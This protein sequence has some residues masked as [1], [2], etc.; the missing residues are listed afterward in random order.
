MRT[1]GYKHLHPHACRARAPS[2]A[3]GPLGAW[4]RCGPLRSAA[5]QAP[6][7]GHSI[8]E[9]RGGGGEGSKRHAG[10]RRSVVAAP[11][12]VS[13][14]RAGSFASSSPQPHVH[15][16][17]LC[18]APETWEPA[19][20]QASLGLPA[21]LAR[22]LSVALQGNP[23][24]L[25]R[26]LRMSDFVRR[27]EILEQE[28]GLTRE[29]VRTSPVRLQ[30]DLAWHAG[31]APGQKHSRLTTAPCFAGVA[32]AITPARAPHVPSLRVAVP[33]GA[34]R[35]GPQRAAG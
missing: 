22:R 6:S 12:A 35:G 1:Q 19:S 23:D 5:S 29:Q 27:C 32:H 14:A 16:C 30:S 33:G 13:A 3:A 31:G 4:Q 18:A 34:A 8:C 24:A 17:C 7:R 25:P 2:Q 15:M 21:R 20:L 26:R 9:L 10:G 28:L 11:F